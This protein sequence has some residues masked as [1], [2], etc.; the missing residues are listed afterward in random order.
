MFR[1]YAI[2]F[3]PGGMWGDAGAAWLGWDNRSGRAT[4]QPQGADPALTERPRKYGFH[5]TLKAPFAIADGQTPDALLAATETHARRL[6]PIPLPSLQVSRIGRFFAFTAPDQKAPLSALAGALVRE[7]D[8]FRAP[9]AEADLQR[10]RAAR[11]TDAQDALLLDWGYP[12]V[13]EEFR[14]HLTLTGPLTDG[15]DPA[16]AIHAHFSEA[17]GQG[18]TLDSVSIVGERTDGH[19]EQIARFDLA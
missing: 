1:R 15:P 11:L 6:Q 10:R 8:P 5:A 9:L 16:E 7:L 12:Y 3:V 17:L 19:F 2:Y 18:L 4:A 14:F 13:M